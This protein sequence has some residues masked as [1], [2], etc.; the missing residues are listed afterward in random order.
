MI[1]GIRGKTDKADEAEADDEATDDQV[2]VLHGFTTRSARKA[3]MA[4]HCVSLEMVLTR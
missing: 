2:S 3:P 4:A 1:E